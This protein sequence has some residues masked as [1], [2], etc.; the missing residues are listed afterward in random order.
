MTERLKSRFQVS[1]INEL[2]VREA[3]IDGGGLFKD[4]IDTLAKHAFDPQYGLFK[5]TEDNVST[6]NT[7]STT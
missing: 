3:G 6:R 5:Q 7:V 1:F 4:Y 2:G